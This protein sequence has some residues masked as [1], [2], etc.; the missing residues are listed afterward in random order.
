MPALCSKMWYICRNLLEQN[1]FFNNIFCELSL[2]P[3]FQKVKFSLIK[4]QQHQNAQNWI[5]ELEQKVHFYLNGLFGLC[6]H[7][8]KYFTYKLIFELLRLSWFGT[9]LL[10]VRNFFNTRIVMEMKMTSWPTFIYCEME[11]CNL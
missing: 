9:I 3:F 7:F 4:L 11:N 8:Y 5:V 1:E 6:E 2:R 10:L